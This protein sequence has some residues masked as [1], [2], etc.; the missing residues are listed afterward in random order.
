MRPGRSGHSQTSHAVLETDD[1]DAHRD[2]KA[3][4]ER[5][6]AL[7]EDEADAGAQPSAAG[8]DSA[9]SGTQDDASRPQRRDDTGDATNTPQRAGSLDPNAKVFVPGPAGAEGGEEG[10][11]V[12]MRDPDTE[13]EPRRQ[14]EAGAAETDDDARRTDREEG[15]MTD[16]REEGEM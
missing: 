2:E 5:R 11:D 15:Q 13:E 3:E 14:A 12:E 8:G 9:A 6:R 4:Q 16:D 1:V 7:D 10:E